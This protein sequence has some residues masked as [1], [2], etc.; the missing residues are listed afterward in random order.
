MGIAGRRHF[1]YFVSCEVKAK[2]GKTKSCFFIPLQRGRMNKTKWAALVALAVTAPTV[3][4]QTDDSMW[5]VRGMVGKASWSLE[6][7][8]GT[9][10]GKNKIEA[11]YEYTGFGVSY[12]NNGF[13]V[14]ALMKSADGG[15]YHDL[16]IS[17]S[18]KP[19]FFRDEVNIS[20]GASTSAGQ[21]FVGYMQTDTRLYMDRW[22]GNRQAYDNLKLNGAYVGWGIN[23]PALGGNFNLNFSV[24]GFGGKIKENAAT[25]T[26]IEADMGLGL[27]GGAS[28]TYFFTRDVGV[29]L[30]AKL[31]SYTWTFFDSSAAISTS[32]T[33]VTE[34]LMSYGISAIVQF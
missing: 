15:S 28:Y 13:F 27:S 9:Y 10:R 34:K 32:T 7:D 16:T 12:V 22:F 20:I 5:R 8:A 6:P 2:Q 24:G 4:A 18:M 21:F 30:D 17:D 11:D 19:M 29:S 26:E 33:D 23:A 25:T 14:D 3:A 31:Q 1:I